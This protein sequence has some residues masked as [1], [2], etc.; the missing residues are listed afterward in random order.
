MND[1]PRRFA[2]GAR[3]VACGWVAVWLAAPAAAPTRPPDATLFRVFLTDGAT[4]VSYGEYA[5]VGDKVII[6]LPIA[7]GEAP[8]RLQM[9]SIPASAVDWPRTEAYTDAARAARYGATNGGNDYALL[10]EAVARALNEIAL[11]KDPRRRLA[12]AVEARRNVVQWPVD[13]FGYR[14]SDVAQLAELFDEAISDAKAASGDGRFDLSLV[15]NTAGPPVVALM[16]PPTAREQAEQALKAA[17]LTDDSGER[18][19]LL[20]AIAE[21]LGAAPAEAWATGVRTHALLALAAERRTDDAYGA[22]TR[23]LARTADA[24]V[25]AGDPRGVER[26]IRRALES[27]DRFG[28]RRPQEMAALLALLDSRLDTARRM[29]LARDQW[30]QRAELVRRYEKAIAEPASLMRASRA[31]L[32][33]IKDLAGPSRRSLDRLNDRVSLA[34]RLLALVKPPVEVETAQ[35]LFSSA[36]QMAVRAATVRQRAI[37]SGD[38]SLA[39]QASSAAAGAL[40]MFQSASEELERLTRAPEAK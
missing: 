11:T 27:D 2:R 21:S 35:A 15:A 1:V 31:W 22:L 29:R 9:V 8:P 38:M 3:A 34:G 17:S 25:R 16:V 26:L 36:L 39:W 19:S 24:R 30:A 33:Q 37:D 40:M 13:H 5:R 6:S 28:H 32:E 12:M 23:D 4:L 7:G 14:A 18:R 20:Q 10:T